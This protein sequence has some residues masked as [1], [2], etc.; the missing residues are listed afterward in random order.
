MERNTA[1]TSL[2][3]GNQ[4]PAFI[5]PSTLGESIS[6]EYLAD[7]RAALIVFTCNH[8]PYVIGSEAMLMETIKEFLPKGLKA[9]LISANDPRQYPED[10]FEKMVEKTKRDFLPCPY[11]FDESQEV[12]RAFDAQ[13]TPECYLFD[14]KNHLVFHGTV[15]NSPR[16]PEMVET[17]FLAPA[18]EQVLAGKLPNPQFV[19]PI[20]CSIKW[21]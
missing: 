18:I 13:C 8:C 4:M 12:A 3:F 16:Y 11:L 7:A 14:H 6:Q 15:N 10:S 19:H 21:K 9:V 5:L 17:N 20:G 2:T 1:S